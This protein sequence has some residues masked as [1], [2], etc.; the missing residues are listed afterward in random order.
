[1]NLKKRGKMILQAKYQG[2][3]LVL[4]KPQAGFGERVLIAGVPSELDKQFNKGQD[5]EVEYVS[6]TSCKITTLP[7]NTHDENAKPEG[8]KEKPEAAPPPADNAATKE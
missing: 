3:G 8:D 7:N 2:D 5:V 4:V 6:Q 1:M